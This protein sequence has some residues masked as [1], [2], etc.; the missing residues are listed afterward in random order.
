MRTTIRMSAELAR[1]AKEFAAERERTLTQVIEDA[2]AEYLA[3]QP[4]PAARKRVVLPVG[5]DPRHK[6]TAEEI[7]AAIE[8]ADVEYDLNKL[9]GGSDVPD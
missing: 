7:R 5:G 6:V 8:R 1:R 4:R 3:R 9:R 2:V